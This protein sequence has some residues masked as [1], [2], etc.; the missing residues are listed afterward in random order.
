M[1]PRSGKARKE[2]RRLI[3]ADLIRIKGSRCVCCG[4]NA[5]PEVLEFHHVMPENKSFTLSGNALLENP[6]DVVL[7]EASKCVLV[8]PTCH[9]EIHQG[10]K[11]VYCD[12]R[13]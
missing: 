8:C 1:P 13:R 9:K 5:Y 4:Y 7:A 2:I 10:Y 12:D 6:V 11:V 3:R